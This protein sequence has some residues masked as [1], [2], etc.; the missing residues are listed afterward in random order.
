MRTASGDVFRFLITYE[1]VETG[2]TVTSRRGVV[3]KGIV[4]Q[5]VMAASIEELL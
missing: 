4:P 2:N 3:V 1:S 5:T